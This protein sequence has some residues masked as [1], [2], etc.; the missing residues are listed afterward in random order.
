MTF[1]QFKSRMIDLLPRLR[2]FALS[3][4][5]Y[6]PDADDLVQEACTTALLKWDQYD[7]AQP[8]DR[9]MF[10]V[11]RNLWISEIRKRKVRVGAG[12]VPAEEE[13]GLRVEDRI[14]DQLAA[15]QARGKIDAMPSDLSQPLMLV[16]SEG[17]SYR[18]V[19]ELLGIPIGTVMS[20]VH[21][22]RQTL[23]TALSDVE[24]IA[25]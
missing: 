4:T 10:R 13:P 7:P 23:I 5:R 8:L 21:R 11:L 16:C 1:D 22:A 12:Q 9:W 2:R 3:L 25:K 15:Q 19:S 18:E 6:G 24:S 17:Y 14:V 20:R